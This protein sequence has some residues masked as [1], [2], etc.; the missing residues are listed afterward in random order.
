MGLID[1]TIDISNKIGALNDQK[2]DLNN[3]I[4][5]KL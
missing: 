3:K 1:E 5:L 4:K 2:S